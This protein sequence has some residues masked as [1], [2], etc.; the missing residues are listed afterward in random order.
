MQTLHYTNKTSN[1]EAFWN[2]FRAEF[3][4][5]PLYIACG[6]YDA[7]SAIIKAINDTQS[8]DHLDI[9]D[10]FESWTK[11]NP[12]PG[13]SG[14]GAWWPGSHDL[15]EGYPFGFTLWCQ[16]RNDGTK[17]TIPSPRYH[18]GL[19]GFIPPLYPDWMARGAYEVAPW[20]NAT[21]Y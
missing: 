20:V 5:D 2:A 4:H 3:G 10:E 12:N 19:G 18:A 6:A 8:F 14:G 9:I 17:V 21:W 11:S 15:V 16:W 1:S 7:A 13:V